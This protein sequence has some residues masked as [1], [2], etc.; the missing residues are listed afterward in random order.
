MG[1]C[2]SRKDYDAVQS[3]LSLRQKC[4]EVSVISSVAASLREDEDSLSSLEPPSP[5][6]RPS[7]IATNGEVSS[8][9]PSPVSALLK[10]F[11][12]T[13]NLTLFNARN[14]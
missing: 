9:C 8:S 7:I 5:I 1:Y 3:L 14:E 12:L 2:E 11:V 6:N 4:S 10:I 13:H